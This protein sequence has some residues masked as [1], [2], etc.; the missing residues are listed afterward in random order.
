LELFERAATSRPQ[1]E[2]VKNNLA[3]AILKC[4]R[5]LKRALAL[6]LEAVEFRPASPSFRDTLGGIYLALAES[7][8]ESDPERLEYLRAAEQESKIVLKIDPKNLDYRIRIA[9]VFLGLEKC[10]D[11]RSALKMAGDGGPTPKQ[12][13][14]ID[15]LTEKLADC[16]R[17]R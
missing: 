5:D 2:L 16:E 15:I 3:Y 12:Q 10:G 4:G 14:E 1:E 9:A 8:D 7:L 6:S 11:A 17:D 13:D